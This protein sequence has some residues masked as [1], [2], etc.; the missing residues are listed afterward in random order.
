[1]MSLEQ[2]GI[3]SGKSPERVFF[4]VF[5]IY[6]GDSPLVAQMGEEAYRYYDTDP[7]SSHAEA[8]DIAR[9]VAISTA[10]EYKDAKVV[11]I[12]PELDEEDESPVIN[13]FDD[14]V[15]FVINDSDGKQI[16]LIGI[17][18]Q[19]YRRETIH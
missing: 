8:Y 13:E 5:L 17:S 6:D 2:E 3:Y 18:G 14:N 9:Q 19:D 4:Q 15:W 7:F 11:E 1:M 16:A 10:G 12:Q